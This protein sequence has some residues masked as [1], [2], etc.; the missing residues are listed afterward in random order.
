[1]LLVNPP[2]LLSSGAIFR[3][4]RKAPES[5]EESFGPWTVEIREGS[6]G[7]VVRGGAATSP[8]VAWT[9][10]IEVVQ[11]ALDLLSVRGVAD[12]AIVDAEDEHIVW[13]LDQQRAT[14]RLSATVTMN[15]RMGTPTLVVRDRS[16]AVIP[17]PL[18]PALAWHDSFRYFRQ[19]QITDDLFDAFRNMYLALEALLST[20]APMRV[21][22]NG[23][24]SEGE[25][26]WFQRAL[27]EANNYIQLAA[28]APSAG[29]SDPVDD[30]CRDLYGTYRTAL[31][32][33]K[34]GRPVFLPHT[35]PQR[36]AIAT[37][38]QRCTKLYMALAEAV[39]GAHRLTG[40]IFEYFFRTQTE[41]WD[42]DLVI[43]ASDDTMPVG[44]NDTVINP[45]GGQV[46]A[47]STQT[48]PELESP[49]VRVFLGKAP[50]A[51]LG[52]LRHIARIMAT[53]LRRVPLFGHGE[54]GILTLEGIEGFEA[55]LSLRARNTRQVRAQYAT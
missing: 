51:C 49:F 16:G 30:I 18:P 8:T 34:S 45:S 24:P 31:F 27:T 19:S 3:L 6:L 35:S 53:D 41:Q 37:S 50:V 22:P 14:L 13:W 46:V 21:K 32:H 38:V 29:S 47:L 23:R 9:E 11:Q 52:T 4:N 17:Q 20:I 36:A 55:A 7:I 1:M 26:E 39:L 44:P 25:G 12:L 5:A 15:F 43:Y 48:A 28:F 10:A 40:G 2:N 33:A 54:E 42:R